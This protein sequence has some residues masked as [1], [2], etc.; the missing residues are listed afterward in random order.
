M[1]VESSKNKAKIHDESDSESNESLTNF[2]REKIDDLTAAYD[3]MMEGLC[4]AA[5]DSGEER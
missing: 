1:R 2:S 4:E 3:E 5:R